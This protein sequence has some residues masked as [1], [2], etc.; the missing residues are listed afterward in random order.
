MILRACLPCVACSATNWALSGFPH[1]RRLSVRS[2]SD[3]R[4]SS[5][6]KETAKTEPRATTVL[7]SISM[8]FLEVFQNKVAAEVTVEVTPSG[9]HVIVAGV[10]ELDEVFPGLNPKMAD[11]LV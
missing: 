1:R 7:P 11:V 2:K 4:R 3:N 6:A 9:M 10:V 8:F 5:A